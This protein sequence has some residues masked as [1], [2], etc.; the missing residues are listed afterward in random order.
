M[1]KK[2]KI[3]Y[4]PKGRAKEYSDLAINLAIG[5]NHACEY[6]Y[7]PASMHKTREV[8]NEGAKERVDVLKLLEKDAEQIAGDE[9]F[10]L[11]SF[12]TDPY[13]TD[14]AAEL[15][16][17]ALLICEKYDLKCQ[18]LTKAGFR[19]EKDFEIFKRNDWKFGSTIIFMDEALREKWE[20]GAPTIESRINSLKKAHDMGIYTWVSVEPVVDA[21]E[22]L[23]VITTLKEMN[24]VDLWKVGKL[25]HMADVE[26]GIDWLRFLNETIELLRGTEFIIKEDLRKFAE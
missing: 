3:I 25:N 17:Q 21:V 26:K 6:C 7:G 9:R 18:V 2:L 16:R 11:F 14:E 12:A 24:A 8:W 10:I 19:A 22:A 5:C 23:K 1:E 15:T 20:P 13:C 4:E